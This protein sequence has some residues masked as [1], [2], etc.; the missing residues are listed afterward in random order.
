VNGRCR[1]LAGALVVAGTVGGSISCAAPQVTPSEAAGR[2][3][4][5]QSGSDFG[6][7]WTVWRAKGSDGGVCVSVDTKPNLGGVSIQRGRDGSGQHGPR[8]E[9]P[10]H[11]GRTANCVVVDDPTRVP[12][13]EVG[14]IEPLAVADVD[15]LSQRGPG[16]H[17]V[18][19]VV[20][21]AGSDVHAVFNDGSTAALTPQD[22]IAFLVWN[23][24]R[25]LSF[26][27]L[28]Y[29]GYE[30]PRLRCSG[31]DDRTVLDDLGGIGCHNV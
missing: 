7:T 16:P 17:Y 25:T 22:G 3:R 9:R 15:S 28:T 4:S 19:V 23:D 26:V 27:D 8:S 10:T 2:W 29:P 30:P 31:S 21:P 20:D 12:D 1:L 6:V 5:V 14:A 13:D 18:A 11:A 24:R